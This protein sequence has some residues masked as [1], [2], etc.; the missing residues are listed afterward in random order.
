MH[1]CLLFFLFI[2]LP[3][4]GFQTSLTSNGKKI[5]WKNSTVPLIINTNTIDLPS[6]TTRNLINA[7]IAQWNGVT[8]TQIVPNT[9]ANNVIKFQTD[10]SKYGSAVIGVTEV[11]TNSGGEITNAI[12]RLNDNYEFT[13]FPGLYA[14]GEIYLSDVVT[15]E[16]GHLLGMA[17]S[18]VL[19][20]T[21][22]YSNFS[23]QSDLAYDDK[24]G[25]RTK[26]D[27]G[28]GRIYGYVKGGSDIGVLGVQVQLISMK[29]GDTIGA[30]TDESGYFDIR[31]LDLGDTFYI[32]TSSIKNLGSLPGIYSNVQTEFCPASYVGSFYS[33]CGSENDGFPQG[34]TLTSSRTSVNVGAVTIN[35]DLSTNTDYSYQKLQTSFAPQVVYNYGD[36]HKTE[37]SFVG[38][39]LTPGTSSWSTPDILDVDLRD[40]PLTGSQKYLKV[41][42]ISQPFGN[43]LEYTMDFA[44]NGVNLSSSHQEKSYSFVNQTYSTNMEVLLPL[45]A[46]AASNY[47]EISL[48]AKKLSSYYIAQTFPSSDVFST[49]THLP[50]LLMMSIW[51]TQGSSIVPVLN[52]TASLSDNQS[53]LDAPF[54]YSVKNAKVANDS[55]AAAA[56][57]AGASCGT[58]DTDN[59]G[60]GNG[61]GSATLIFGMMLGF[62]LVSLGKRAKNFLS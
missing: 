34:I 10:F 8:S 45:S 30:I 36:Q 33:A 16:L 29:T 53:C 25:V 15:H 55:P 17:H 2:A 24:A 52:T 12:V 6:A 41:S 44:Q 60:D 46:T 50:Y 39:F 47:F 40:Y 1:L 38:Y 22:F 35:C 54:T 14:S 51:E 9:S 13:A 5:R 42:L 31:G 18:E 56:S 48:A 37:Q 23:G 11:S 32:Y 21:M 26:Y 27:S 4:W 28:F 61:P 49:G 58:I 62:V 7:S 57:A 3:C 43:Q 20:S 59:D 19:N